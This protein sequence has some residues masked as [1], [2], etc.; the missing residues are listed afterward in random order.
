MNAST[1]D[2]DSI[3]RKLRDSGET[4]KNAADDVR[5]RKVLDKMGN[6]VGTVV[7]LMIDDAQHKVR[8]LR[9][10]D[11][12]FLGLGATHL[13]IPVDAI[14]RITDDAV[15]ID[16]SGEHI[17]GAPRYD[18][19]LVDETNDEYWGGVANYYGVMPYWGMGYRYPMYPYYTAR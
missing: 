14:S 15:T 7:G 10:E 9:V 2:S 4:V 13:M 17:K 5:G 6:K 11:G 16:R 18:P 19:A 3:L 12:G 1:S 8:F